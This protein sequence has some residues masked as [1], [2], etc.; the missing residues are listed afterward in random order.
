MSESR[1]VLDIVLRS[2]T[3]CQTRPFGLDGSIV[4]MPL[5]EIAYI[6]GMGQASIAPILCREES[7][8]IPP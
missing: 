3:A 4:C 7:L 8:W 5:F 6:N 1:P 2:L